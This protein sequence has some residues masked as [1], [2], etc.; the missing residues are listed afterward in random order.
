MQPD[1]L[2][3]GGGAAGL[4]SAWHLARAGAR[5]LLLEAE[6]Q[7]GVHS[8]GQNAAILR[9]LI[10]SP[11]RTRLAR[12]A[13]LSLHRPPVGFCE[14]PLIDPVGLLL[15]ADAG[16]AAD[17]AMWVQAAGAAPY[18]ECEATAINGA[19]IARLLPHFQHPDGENATGLYMPGEG[20]IDISLLV[21]SFAKGARQ[22]GAELRTS[23]AVAELLVAKEGDVPQITGARLTSGETIPCERVLLAAGA[24][25]GKL[26]AQ[27]GSEL[28]FFPR[29]R[30]LFVTRND[31]KINPRLPVVWNHGD[32]AQRRIFYMR[33]ESGGMLLCACDEA[34]IEPT[35]AYPNGVCPKDD[36]VLEDI[37]RAT[38]LFAP[39]F[40]DAEIASWWSGWRTFSEDHDFALGADPKVAGL[41]WCAGLAGHGM[42][43]SFEAGRLA[44]ASASEGLA[45]E[46]SDVLSG[47]DYGGTFAP[48]AY[49]SPSS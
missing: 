37:A 47:D 23:C 22:A 48:K 25:A 15:T 18:A 32:A 9:T 7:L 33:P 26:G 40:A 42:T 29:R 16:L 44:A 1:V 21:D 17:L 6:A 35:S 8:S 30:H 24:W 43:A 14:A 13:A 5:V 41:H 34:L 10:E 36:S 28:R 11:M 45:C 3:L 39:D 2:I 49:L 19:E 12:K 31:D 4:S 38:Q 27:A 20:Q 46:S